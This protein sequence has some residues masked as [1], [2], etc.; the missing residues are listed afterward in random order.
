[1]SS[2]MADGAPACLFDRPETGSLMGERMACS[3]RGGNAEDPLSPFREN[4]NGKTFF[5]FAARSSVHKNNHL[6]PSSFAGTCIL[7]TDGWLRSFVPELKTAHD[8]SR[9]PPT[10]C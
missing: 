1:M 2:W 6:R 7:L 3:E 4:A 10:L 9:R 8:S 5:Y